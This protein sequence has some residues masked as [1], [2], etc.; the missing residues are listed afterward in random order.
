MT[1]E[2]RGT[3]GESESQKWSNSAG[4]GILFSRA[5]SPQPVE[6]HHIMAG[7]VLMVKAIH[8]N[9]KSPMC[10]C[11]CVKY[12]QNELSKCFMQCYW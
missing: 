11:P 3:G 8:E 4:V 9:V 12:G 10:I 5:F 1:V 2:M 7:H 6:L